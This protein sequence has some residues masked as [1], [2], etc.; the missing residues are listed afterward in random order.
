MNEDT[1]VLDNRDAEPGI[2]TRVQ[3]RRGRVVLHGVGSWSI[4]ASA[5]DGFT[6]K[7]GIDATRP[8]D[9]EPAMFDRAGL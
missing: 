2:E 4:D 3:A 1:D 5:A 7:V 9:A 8:A 6:T